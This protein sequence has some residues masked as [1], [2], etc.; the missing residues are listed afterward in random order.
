MGKKINKIEECYYKNIIEN[1]L[2]VIWECDLKLKFTYVNKSIYYH[3]G[4]TVEEWIG[5]TFSLH[6][7][8]REFWKV[9]RILINQTNNFENRNPARFETFIR[10]K[11]GNIIHFEI[12]A[13]FI[14]NSNGLPMKIIGIARNINEQKKQS[15]ELKKI[16]GI[17]D[18]LFSIL[19]HDLRG[20][21]SSVLGFSD[22]LINHLQFGN[23][24]KINRLTHLLN[25]SCVHTFNLLDSMLTWAKCQSNEIKYN[26][27]QIE[28]NGFIEK[29]IKPLILQAHLKNIQINIDLE[30]KLNVIADIAMLKVIITNLVTNAI[31][32]TN[33]N[34][35]VTITCCEEANVYKFSIIDT[36]VGM[37]RRKV[38]NLFDI[39]NYLSTPG[40]DGE[41]GVGLGLIICKDFV[42][43]HNGHIG[44]V[45]ELGK[46]STF[47]FTIPCERCK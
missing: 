2:D 29:L 17:K 33:K 14:L 12:N 26:P 9:A 16:Q 7:A 32:F 44:V 35:F 47:W 40:T 37:D 41:N 27:T 36:G 1:S 22:L 23:K 24:N 18:K 43:K 21:F 11:K 25:E 38:K 10:N 8:H 15:A 42:G 3:T 30:D 31:K 4:Y 39:E 20:S 45:S 5:T 46:G 6:T 34:G 13:N 28:L 19:T